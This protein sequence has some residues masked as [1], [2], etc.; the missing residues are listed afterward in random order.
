ME[1]GVH[2]TK[3]TNVHIDQVME[4]WWARK[5]VQDALNEGVRT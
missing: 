1:K 5:D 3:E 4:E 2:N